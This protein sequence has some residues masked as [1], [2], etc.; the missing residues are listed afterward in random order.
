[1]VDPGAVAE[2]LESKNPLC[3][4]KFVLCSFISLRSINVYLSVMFVS[5]SA[6]DTTSLELIQLVP[7]GKNPTSIPDI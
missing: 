1:M 5:S 3:C 4:V 6:D 7:P 2:H